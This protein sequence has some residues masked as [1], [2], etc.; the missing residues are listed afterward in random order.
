L[1][2][3]PINDT[4]GEN[5]ETVIVTLASNAAYEI[6]Q[7]SV[8]TVT[9]F[10][11]EPRITIEVTDAVATEAPTVTDTGRFT[12]FRTGSTAASLLVS[13][14]LTGSTAASG[15]DY[16]SIG[17]SVTIPAGASSAE[18]TITPLNNTTAEDNESV[19]V[20]ISPRTTYSIGSPSSAV[21]TIIDDELPR[22][23]VA[24]SDST[25]SEPGTDQGEFRF[26][27]VGNTLLPVTISFSVT[28]TA[29]SDSDYEALPTTVTIP[30]GSSSTTLPVI[31]LD[32]LNVETSEGVTV[33]ITANAASYTIGSPSI[34]T[35]NI[36][37]DE[38][39]VSITATDSAASETEGD[40]G[41]FTISRTG[42][43]AQAITVNFNV[44]GT[45]S[46]GV[47]YPSLGSSITIPEGV[48]SVTLAVTPNDNQ[49]AENNET[50]TLTL[51]AGTGYATFSPTSG[52]V[53]IIDDDPA[54]VSLAT[55]DANS[56][57]P[58]TDTGR[59]TVS[60]VGNTLAAL[61]INYTIGGTATNGTDYAL[62][63]GVIT[64]PQGASSAVL[65]V[66]ALDDTSPELDE[67][68]VLTLAEG[69][70]YTL[71]TAFS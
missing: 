28:G 14:A 1:S 23:S 32:D 42:S 18:L 34:A 66:T 12:I 6:A 27:R 19:V 49:I 63:S 43:T 13:F 62:L 58:G 22:V 15:S 3:T 5:D 41:L 4:T 70:A 53:T 68:V 16:T 56:S 61:D 11:N 48:I 38:P 50:V 10:D 51:A 37:D 64:I 2:V 20:A 35:V 44:S 67:T 25:L 31:V 60:R 17:T 55:N 39:R 47:D 36:L 26:T 59:F 24:L 7:P 69:P 54:L 65:T 30:L 52:T 9:I 33:T 40:N 46:P 29:T 71:G 21:V 57:E 8:A 45:A